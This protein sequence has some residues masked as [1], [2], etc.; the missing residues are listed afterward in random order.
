MIQRVQSIWLLLASV[1]AFLSLK[2]P[3]YSGTNSANVPSYR[4]M[5]TENFY[6]MLLTVIIG[7]IA[8]FNIFLYSNRKLQLRLCILG[9]LL[10]GLLIF[11][12][13]KKSTTFLPGTGTYALTSILQVGVLVSYAFAMK[14]I[15][16]D[17]KI[18]KESNRLR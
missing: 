11:L 10:E 12:Y 14:G 1:C 8:V 2:M 4:L 6:F 16:N 13:Y 7:V 18:V 9:I 3:F 15:S 17:N 5:G